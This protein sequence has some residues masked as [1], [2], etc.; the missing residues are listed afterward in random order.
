MLC[1]MVLAMVVTFALVL[2]MQMLIDTGKPAGDFKNVSPE[3]RPI[4]IEYPIVHP[5]QPECICFDLTDFPPTPLDKF[6]LQL[7]AYEQPTVVANSPSKIGLVKVNQS[8]GTDDLVLVVE[9][10]PRYPRRTFPYAVSGRVVLDFTVNAEGRV[11]NIEILSES[12]RGGGFAGTAIKALEK[13]RFKP[14]Y[15]NGNPV[16]TD[17]VIHTFNFD[18]DKKT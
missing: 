11:E 2:Q 10:T 12:P 4:W 8:F 5:R 7:L 13:S 18:I 15:E 6:E 1:Q 3:K 9:V 16:A 17:H 14:R